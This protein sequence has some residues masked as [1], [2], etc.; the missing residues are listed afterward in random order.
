MCRQYY[1]Y[2]LCKCLGR[3]LRQ[4]SQIQGA[5]QLSYGRR[6]QEGERGVRR[7]RG[8]RV[9]GHG[10]ELTGAVQHGRQHLQRTRAHLQGEERGGRCGDEARRKRSRP[11]TSGE[12]FAFGDGSFRMIVSRDR[13]AGR[14]TGESG[15][16]EDQYPY[17]VLFSTPL[18][19]A[20]RQF[21]AA[22]R[23]RPWLILQ[24]EE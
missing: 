2:N 3:R 20:R 5:V 10:Q 9:F 13:A 16:K 1:L 15:M 14:L 21:S 4:Q 8:R 6:Q 17:R 11:T 18:T 19:R 23:T 7:R 22:W 24:G 12:D